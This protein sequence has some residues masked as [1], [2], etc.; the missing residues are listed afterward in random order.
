[1]TRST[2]FL[3]SSYIRKNSWMYLLWVRGNLEYGKMGELNFKTYMRTGLPSRA[4]FSASFCAL[5]FRGALVFL[6][7]GVYSAST[8]LALEEALFVVFSA[9]STGYSK[10]SSFLASAFLGGLPRR[11]LTTGCS[12]S[13]SSFLLLVAKP[14]DI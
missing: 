10:V 4:A 11:F 13:G 8:V 2:L 5:V 12:A 6:T 1:M 9:F 14:R 3:S 7:I